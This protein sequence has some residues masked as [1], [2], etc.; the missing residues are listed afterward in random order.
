MP[1][2]DCGYVHK[3][4]TSPNYEFRCVINNLLFIFDIGFHHMNRTV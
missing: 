2:K 4:L 3:V 1:K